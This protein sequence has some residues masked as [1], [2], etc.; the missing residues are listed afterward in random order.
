MSRVFPEH[1]AGR[2]SNGPARLCPA[3]IRDEAGWTDSEALQ[4]RAPFGIRLH[5]EDQRSVGLAMQPTIALKLG[6]DLTRRPSCITEREQRLPGSAP[7]GYGAQYVERGGERDIFGNGQGGFAAVVI[8]AV[9]YKAAAGFDR[10]AVK[11]RVVAG[12]GRSLNL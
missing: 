9:E 2:T 3:G 6:F 12:D 7:L 8:A 5:T 10:A 1:R 11:N 4:S